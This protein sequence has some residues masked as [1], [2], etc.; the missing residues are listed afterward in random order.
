MAPFF[1]HFLKIVCATSSLQI[2]NLTMITPQW[3]IGPV[4]DRLVDS[5]DQPVSYRAKAPSETVFLLTQA[6]IVD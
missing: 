4:H 6:T 2:L 3:R 5:H 1:S